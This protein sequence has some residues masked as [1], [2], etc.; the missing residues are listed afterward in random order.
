M[1]RFDR[2][3]V[4]AE[5]DLSFELKLWDAGLTAIAGID[6]AGRGALAGPVSAAAVILPPDPEMER[7]LKGVRDSKQLSP[8]RRE[9]AREKILQYASAWG[10]GYA[11]SEE[12]D[13]IGILPATRLAA[14]RALEGLSIPPTHIL[15]D[16]LFLPE[17]PVPQTALIKGDC[18]SLSIAAASILA[19]TSRDA[20]LR[21]LELT[22]PGYG[23]ATHKGY[24]TVAHRS[25]LQRL[26]VCPVHRR[27]FALFGEPGG[28]INE[29][30][31][32]PDITSPRKMDQ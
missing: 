18:R 14:W 19:K 11:T 29:N 26:G 6:E 10:V 28:P 9:T 5:P 15:L 7:Y 20:V 27:S 17:I 30:Q 22:Y 31:P 24:G 1:P 21:E 4:P 32:E 8:E 12:I 13:Q 23:F 16:Y 3:L 25:A 2:S